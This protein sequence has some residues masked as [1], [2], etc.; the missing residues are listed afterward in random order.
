M[1]EEREL[2]RDTYTL[3]EDDENGV[4]SIAD[5]VVAMIAS[6]AAQ[7][8]EGVSG[9]VDNITNE[10]MSRV[11]VKKLTKGVKVAVN[12]SS[13]KVDIAIQIHYGHSIPKTSKDVQ[14]KVKN[15]IENMTGLTV[16]AVNVR[17]AGI[18]VKEV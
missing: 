17:I 1:A 10:L 18:N 14:T 3:K 16:E 2:I 15:S 8:V 7:E 6:I 13:V 12:E 11:G 9:M 4:I 5:D